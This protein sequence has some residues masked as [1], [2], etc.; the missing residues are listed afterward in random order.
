MKMDGRALLFCVTMIYN[1]N[2]MIMV[3]MMMMMTMMNNN[4]SHIGILDAECLCVRVEM[5]R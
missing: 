1:K 5:V 4:Q 2:M 3:K